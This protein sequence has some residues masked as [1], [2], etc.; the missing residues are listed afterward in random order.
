MQEGNETKSKLFVPCYCD[1]ETQICTLAVVEYHQDV[2][3]S[4]LWNAC[5]LN[6]LYCCGGGDV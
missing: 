5:A 6:H 2:S 4:I 3:H 1:K